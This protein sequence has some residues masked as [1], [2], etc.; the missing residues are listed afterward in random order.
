MELLPDI[1]WK[2]F[3]KNLYAKVMDT[4]VFSH[5]AQIGFYFSFAFFPLLLFL[6]SLFG[7]VLESTDNLRTELYVYLA[8]IMPASAYTL[9]Q[10]TL[11]EVIENSSGGKLT[12][13]IFVTL[14]SAS[15]GVDSLRNSLN[16]VYEL[17]E[18]RPWWKNKLQSLILTLMF[19]LLIAFALTSV[20]AGIK[21]FEV[22]LGSIG[23]DVTSSWV[24]VAIQWAAV[25]VLLLLA[26]AVIYSWLPCFEEFKWVWISP[27]AVVA[28][29]L[30]L[31]LS[32]G[33]RLYL[34][35]FNSYNKTYGSLGAVIILMLWM[36]LTGMA[37]LVGGAINSVLTEMTDAK[38]DQVEGEVPPQ[39]SEATA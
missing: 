23:L 8:Q 34:Q 29:L 13:G 10:E 30:W 5:A 21:L 19:I 17:K 24:L 31:L 9:V 1:D 38:K 4:D 15:A 32:G 22:T 11:N 18:S 12:L 36:Y 26:T 25:I 27:G 16:A 7:M 14:W 2:A 37:I 28:I 6:I 20:T 39:Q 35:Y 33:F 3:A